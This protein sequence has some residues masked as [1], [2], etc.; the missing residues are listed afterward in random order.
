MTTPGVITSG[1][2]ITEHP[3]AK[4]VEI[5]RA[6]KTAGKFHGDNAATTPTGW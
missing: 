5:F 4:A 2:I 1:F 6:D 3:A